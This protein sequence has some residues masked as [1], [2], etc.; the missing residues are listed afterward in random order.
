[1]YAVTGIDLK[2][3]RHY[4]KGRSTPRRKQAIKI[5]NALHRL[6]SELLAVHLQQ[7]SIFGIEHL[8]ILVEKKN[9]ENAGGG[10]ICRG[11]SRTAALKKG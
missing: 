11:T 7:Y 8:S 5:E 9:V 2:Q 3:L 10:G 4:A 6:G 1:M